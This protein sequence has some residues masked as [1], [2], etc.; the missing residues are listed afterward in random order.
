VVVDAGVSSQGQLIDFLI[1]QALID[2]AQAELKISRAALRIHAQPAE[3]SSA[4]QRTIAPE[5]QRYYPRIHPP[6]FSDPVRPPHPHAPA[7]MDCAAAPAILSGQLSTA[8]PKLA[9]PL[10][11]QAMA[12]GCGDDVLQAGSLSNSQPDGGLKVQL[13]AKQPEEE[14]DTGDT[15]RRATMVKG[16]LLP[17]SPGQGTDAS[18]PPVQDGADAKTQGPS[19]KTAQPALAP[20][21]SC[22]KPL[23][24]TGISRNSALWTHAEDDE[25]RRAVG[26]HAGNNWKAIAESLSSNKTS[27][28]CLHRWRKVLNPAVVKGNWTQE[29]D[30][31]IRALVKEYGAAKWSQLV[32]ETAVVDAPCLRFT[33]DCQRSARRLNNNPFW[34]AKHLPGR[35][36]KQCRERWYNHLDPTI[37]YSA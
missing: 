5:N 22:I 25:L 36:G 10:P 6:L 28:Q 4:P 12:L 2:R 1:A 11:E 29:E 15:G 37:R 20:Q 34:Q 9:R 14:G 33:S 35:I 13:I 31:K 3:V 27:I 23:L 16:A 7:A 21:H 17:I 8:H 30:D 26:E 32:R 24:N 18:S 19:D